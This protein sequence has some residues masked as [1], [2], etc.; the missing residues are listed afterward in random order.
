MTSRAFVARR[1]LTAFNSARHNRCPHHAH[2]EG[3]TAVHDSTR[4]KSVHAKDNGWLVGWLVATNLSADEG[5][6]YAFKFYS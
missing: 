5:N 4:S 6:H 3:S 1:L 2:T